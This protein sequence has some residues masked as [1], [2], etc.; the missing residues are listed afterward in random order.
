[1]VSQPA[2]TLNGGLGF[3]SLH[4]AGIYSYF[5]TCTY[6]PIKPGLLGATGLTRLRANLERRWSDLRI[7]RAVVVAICA[8]TAVTGPDGHPPGSDERI[9][10]AVPQEPMPTV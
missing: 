8:G 2:V 3:D 5:S 9:D 10:D 1:M 4:Y 7:P 6:A